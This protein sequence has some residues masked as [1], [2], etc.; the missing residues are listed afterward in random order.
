MSVKANLVKTLRDQTGAGMMDCKKALLETGGDLEKSVDWLRKKGLSKAQKKAGRIATEGKVHSYIHGEGRIGVL[1]EVNSETDF[2]SRNED[3][4]DFVANVAMH[5]A[6]SN[7]QFLSQEAIPQ[8]AIEKE[9]EILA[10][11]AREEKKKESFIEKVV[12]GRIQKW[13]KDVCLLDQGY[14]KDPDKTVK[15]YLNE[16]ISSMGENIVIRRFVR[17]ELGEGLEKKK[18]NFAEEVAAQMKS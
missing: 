9:K 6:A 13:M 1:V 10:Q 8:E 7:P 16:T 18:E 2:V 15:D 4:K 3:F 12:E 14:V 5:I 17:Y 11:Q